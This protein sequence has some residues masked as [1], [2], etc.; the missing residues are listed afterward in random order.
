MAIIA[1]LQSQMI[2]ALPDYPAPQLALYNGSLADQ[3]D[4]DLGSKHLANFLQSCREEMIMALQ[5]MGKTNIRELGREDLVCIDREIAGALKIGY[6]GDPCS[7]EVKAS[8]AA[9]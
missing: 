5:A 9:K 6:A 1:A 8:L 3:L 2:K 7:S 4:V